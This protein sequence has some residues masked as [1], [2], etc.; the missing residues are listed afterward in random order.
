MRNPRWRKVIRDLWSN[1]TRTILVVLAIAV[2]IFAFASVFI[3]RQVL[4]ADLN[5]Q[6]RSINASTI[7]MGIPSFGDSLVRWMRHQEQVV[8]AQGRVMQRVKLLRGDQAYNVDLYAFDDYQDMHINRINSEEGAWPPQKRDILLERSS[9]PLT[10]TE[11]GD[12]VLIELPNGRQRKLELIGTVHDLNAIPARLWPEVSAYVSLETMQWLGFPYAYNQLE[13]VARDEF[14]SR[15]K[16]EKLADELE[17]KLSNKGFTVGSVQIREPGEHWAEDVTASFIAILTGIGVFSLVL[18]GFL[19]VNTIT[20]MLAQ[21]RRQVGMMKAIG[22]TGGQIIGIYM[23]MVM[24][25]GLLALFVAL[26]VGAGLA[27]LYTLSMAAFLNINILYFHIPLQ[28]FLLELTAALLVPI[29]AALVPIL[30][31]VRVSA[32]EAISNYGIKS[33][34][35]GGLM[36][37]LLV[38][39]RGLPRPVLLSLRNTFR[40]KGRLFMTLG[41]LVLAGTLFISVVSVRGAMTGEMS[42]VLKMYDFEVQLF[43]DNTYRSRMLENR[44]EHMPGVAEAEGRAY[45]QMQRIRPDRTEGATFSVIGIPPDSDFVQPTLLSGR[46]LEEGDRNAIVL[47]SEVIRDEPD[48][49]AGDEIVLQ[50]GNKKYDWEVVGIIFMTRRGFGYAPFDYLSHV[51]RAYGEASSLVVKTEEKGGQFQSAVARALEDSLKSAGIGVVYALTIDDVIRSSAGRIDFLID[52]LMS[53]AIMAAVIGGLGLAGTMSLNVLERT[54][55]IGVMRSIGASTGMVGTIV[56]TEG[57]LIGLISWVLALPLSV[58]ASLVFNSIVGYAFFDR[59]LDFTFSLTGV[60]MWLVIV[61]VTSVVASL[62]PAH[63]ASVMSIQE[64]LAYE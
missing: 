45:V 50:L 58:P 2:G 11:I 6:Y 39:V 57:M 24:C 3:T 17:E 43:L 52:F 64:T 42:K 9:V 49:R 5:T 13:I 51:N 38:Q 59:P 12:T 26:P 31:G 21:Q 36:D 55:E 60:I 27:Y 22:G 62:L 8:D 1:K 4:M 56:L 29:V 28:V 41:T 33:Q 25:F 53:M 15:A 16:L 61:M 18:S 32:W 7:T 48:I 23:V 37:R 10:G 63:R 44:A 54:R 14:D 19:V 47:N 34:A 40:R 35:G 46:W 20:G 30:N